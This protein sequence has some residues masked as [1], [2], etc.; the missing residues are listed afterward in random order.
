MRF[1]LL[2]CL[3]TATSISAQE[4]AEIPAA[5]LEP[6]KIAGEVGADRVSRKDVTSDW[7]ALAA[8]ADG[9]LWV[10]YVE[11]NG[12]DS[13]RV[14]VRQRDASNSWKDP[15]ELEDGNW[16][17]YLPTIAAVP[18]GAMAFWS[19]RNEGDFDVFGAL[20][21]PDGSVGPIKRIASGS[22]GDFHVRAAASASGE[23]TVVWQSFRDL[24]SDI[25]ARRKTEDGW[26]RSHRRG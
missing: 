26:G 21:T 11:W 12:K 8:G 4:E 7:P 16:D 13:D 20:V 14:V 9:S 22:H 2:A 17:H 25:Y 23:V 6:A 5:E 15:V 24:Q 1:L 3:A 19:G 18:D 10:A